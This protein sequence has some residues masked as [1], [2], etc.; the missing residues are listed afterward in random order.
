MYK[1]LRL[2]ILF[3]IALVSKELSAFEYNGMTFSIISEN[4]KLCALVRSADTPY[5]GDFVIPEYA[6]CDGETYQV[7]QVNSDTF[8]ECS[9]LT[10]LTI[11]PTLKAIKN[12]AFYLCTN[13][14]KITIQDSNETLSLGYCSVNSSVSLFYQSPIHDIYLGRNLSYYSNGN[15]GRYSP[16][17]DLPLRNVYIS[18]YVTE[19]GPYLFAYNK[20]EM[21]GD[22]DTVR[23]PVMISTLRLSENLTSI[24]SSAFNQALSISSLTLPESVVTIG[25]NAFYGNKMLTEIVLGKNVKTIS[26]Y[27]FTNC[28]NIASVYCYAINPPSA[29]NA[30]YSYHVMNARLR[31]PAESVDLYKNDTWWKNFGEILPLDG[32]PSYYPQTYNFSILFPESGEIAQPVKAGTQLA[33]NIKPS[34]GWR[35]HSISHNG[36]DVTHNL[37]ANGDFVTEP[38]NDHTKLNVVFAQDTNTAI[39]NVVDDKAINVLLSQNII[40]ING[41]FHIANLYSIEGT[42]ISSFKENIIDVETPGI[43]ILKV[44]GVTY[45]FMIGR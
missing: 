28:D 35:V 4:E 43:Y 40:T 25:T 3:I 42:L 15:S 38:I 30:A 21:I 13:L 10:S 37:S 8:Y 23:T 45:K 9:E 31:V 2:I 17:C 20:N 7:Y 33:L 39:S 26:S 18:D 16:L 5:S 34:E 27:A 41:D 14:N 36:V 19:L 44:D 24:G 32:I 1:S 11:P 12:D 29:A 6:I 22:D